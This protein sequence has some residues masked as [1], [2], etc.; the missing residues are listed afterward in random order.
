MEEILKKFE[1]K[2]AEALKQADNKEGGLS[3]E[4]QKEILKEAVDEKMT[5]IP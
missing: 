2:R 1:V 3:V 5:E 4:K